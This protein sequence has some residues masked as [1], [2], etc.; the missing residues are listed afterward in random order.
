MPHRAAHAAYVNHPTNWRHGRT[1]HRPG[2]ARCRVS[3]NTRSSFS[4]AALRAARGTYGISSA[5]AARRR[6]VAFSKLMSSAVF[7]RRG[8]RVG[9]V[10]AGA[11]RRAGG[12]DGRTG[13]SWPLATITPSGC[14]A[15]GPGAS[16]PGSGP[17][18]PLARYM[19]DGCPRPAAGTPGT[20]LSGR[21]TRDSIGA[22]AIHRPR[23]PGCDRRWQC[24]CRAGVRFRYW[25]SPR[26]A[27][28]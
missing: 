7:G 2:C 19:A 8:V 14:G 15:G 17:T 3:A 25:Q 23:S 12:R 27:A 13:L 21:P 18:Q 1:H 4:R 9:L 24:Q 26:P 11:L 28:P 6:L 22:E 10:R 20:T 16:S 5:C